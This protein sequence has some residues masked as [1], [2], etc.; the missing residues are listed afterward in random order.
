MLCSWQNKYALVTVWM[1]R[2]CH[3]LSC[4]SQLKTKFYIASKPG[5]LLFILN[6]Y[7]NRNPMYIVFSSKSRIW[8][9]KLT[10]SKYSI[11]LPGKTSVYWMYH[12]DSKVSGQLLTKVK[13]GSKMKI[14]LNKMY[15]YQR[16]KIILISP[17]SPVS[18]KISIR[19]YDLNIKTFCTLIYILNI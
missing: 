6:K 3:F 18:I 9:L 13:N 16:K 14:L 8:L 15:F 11:S 10:F 19:H 1:D 17:K 4:S 12:S 7:V 2:H 5:E